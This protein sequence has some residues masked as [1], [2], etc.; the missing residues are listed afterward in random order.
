MIID[1]EV[2]YEF[3]IGLDYASDIGHQTVNSEADAQWLLHDRDIE[4]QLQTRIKFVCPV[5]TDRE[6]PRDLL[7]NDMDSPYNVLADSGYIPYDDEALSDKL[8]DWNRIPLY[9]HLCFD[10]IPVLIHHNGIKEARACSWDK[11]WYA[12][13]LS[14]ILGH[15]DISSLDGFISYEQHLAKPEQRW[16]G[17]IWSDQGRFM[18]FRKSVKWI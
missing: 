4:P 8:G 15:L 14:D 6:L 16:N 17:G 5:R 1:E 10:K 9:T 3:G 12:P 13:Y 2:D 11:P 18:T 7:H